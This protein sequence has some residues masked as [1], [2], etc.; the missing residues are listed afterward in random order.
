MFRK[1]HSNDNIGT[2][3]KHGHYYIHCTRT[4]YEFDDYFEAKEFIE[5]AYELLAGAW[6]PFKNKP[7]YRVYSHTGHVLAH[8]VDLSA[9][10]QLAHKWKGVCR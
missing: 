8:V 4:S 6:H 3:F 7:R 1:I 10:L 5:D 2:E 9:G